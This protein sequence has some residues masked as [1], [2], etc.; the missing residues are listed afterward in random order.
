MPIKLAR[1]TIK[2]VDIKHTTS[3]EVGKKMNTKKL[4]VQKIARRAREE[5]EYIH[6]NT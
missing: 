2:G 5:M 6:K 1:T 4:S 3:K